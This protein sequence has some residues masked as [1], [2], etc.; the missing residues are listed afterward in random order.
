M[1]R[2][3]EALAALAKRSQ[4]V[5]TVAQLR[6]HEDISLGGFQLGDAD[7]DS[8]RALL[9]LGV[10][11]KLYLMNNQLAGAAAGEALGLGMRANSNLVYLGV[12]SNK[13]GPE[14]IRPI[15]QALATHEC[16]RVL[17]ASFNPLGDAGCAALAKA[18]RSPTCPL[19]ELILRDCQIGDD[20]ALALARALAEAADKGPPPAAGRDGAA[21]GGHGLRELTLEDNA[22]G[23]AG[24]EALLRAG[25]SDA[26]ALVEVDLSRN[27]I[28]SR[29]ARSLV[30]GPFAAGS[31]LRYPLLDGNPTGGWDGALLWIAATAYVH[32]PSD[33]ARGA[34]KP[35]KLPPHRLLAP[36]FGRAREPG[37]GAELAEVLGATFARS[38]AAAVRAA[39]VGCVGACAEL[40]NEVHA[41]EP[42][43]GATYDHAAHIC[44]QAIAGMLGEL[45][46]RG[47][48]AAVRVELS[49]CAAA[50]RWAGVSGCAT[51][52]SAAPVQAYYTDAL[53]GRL[54]E[55]HAWLSAPPDTSAFSARSL[56]ELR[57][58][59][60]GSALGALCRGLLVAPALVLPAR[61][62]A[63]ESWERSL[64]TRSLARTRAQLSLGFVL[65][66][67]AQPL[68]LLALAC[69]PN[70]LGWLDRRLT[71][72]V[73][74]F[75]RAGGK[76]GAGAP[77]AGAPAPG[78]AGG[79]P[80]AASAGAPPAQPGGGIGRAGAS[81]YYPPLRLRLLWAADPWAHILLWWASRVALSVL[82]LGLP[83]VRSAA[84]WAL[85]RADDDARAHAEPRGWPAAWWP[86]GWEGELARAQ[87]LRL[88]VGLWLVALALAQAEML[89]RTVLASAGSSV[90]A[91]LRHYFRDPWSMCIAGG[92]L[93]NLAAV[94]CAGLADGRAAALARDGSRAEAAAG[95]VGEAEGARA[96]TMWG[97]RALGY[98]V[99]LLAF[100]TGQPVALSHTLA[101]RMLMVRARA[102]RARGRAPRGAARRRAPAGLSRARHPAPPRARRSSGWSSTS[103]C[104]S[105]LA[106]RSRSPSPS[107]YTLCSTP[108]ARTRP[109]RRSASTARPRTATRRRWRSALTR[110]G[111]AGR[112]R[113]P[114]ACGPPSSS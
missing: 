15:A 104:S 19:H 46:A 111:S 94:V 16:L 110:M 98:G 75:G 107:G 9:A 58:V 49:A 8:V 3:S 39:L 1:V 97:G 65:G 68:L 87:L 29:A 12:F 59:W 76:G 6:S 37:F 69:A 41:R 43:L 56:L 50:L 25:A 35:P 106:R 70:A 23:D 27:R 92:V 100:S 71:L 103:P 85:L 57:G 112:A 79:T 78:G 60:G 13:L 88:L 30:L 2:D 66:A 10:V 33:R 82:C 42:A 63:R 89:V 54:G 32:T 99:F 36:W 11:K 86:A 102:A 72:S 95:M 4:G 45:R 80:G 44:Q 40:R 64:A 83:P 34:P 22:I 47:G 55:A 21:A 61:W 38:P 84:E 109:R 53:G 74:L 48:S 77:R 52:L 24:A 96:L 67:C 101:P 7:A 73:P 28:T 18:L 108:R 81:S 62:T 26:A 5:Y 14:A 31:R 17:N 91:S 51:T 20:G 114:G 105:P 93:L 113:S 90:S